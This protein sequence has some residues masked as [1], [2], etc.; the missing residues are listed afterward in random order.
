MNAPAINHYEWLAIDIETSNGRPDDAERAMRAWQPAARWKPETIGARYLDALAA[1]REKLAL[2][3]GAP[4]V[5]VALRSETELRCLHSM[6]AEPPKVLGGGLVEGFATQREML[7]ALRAVLE[8]RVGPDTVIVGHNI[9]GFD[10]RKLRWAY[11]RE[12]VRMPGALVDKDQ[13]V[14][15]SMVEY[16]RR[17][18]MEKSELFVGLDALLEEWGIPTHKATV[19]GSMVPQLHAAG[20]YDS[21]VGYCLLDVLAESDVFLRM[22]GRA[23]DDQPPPT[24]ALPVATPLASAGPEAT[25]VVAA[26]RAETS[27][28]AAPAAPAAP[29]PTAPAAGFSF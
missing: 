12:R 23:A 13:P 5:C 1:K 19:D 3:N 4:I 11:L 26:P 8:A 6:R 10:L 16:G 15:D 7:I 27:S 21:I 28:R 17:F 2:L 29:T 20:Q 24:N 14:Y 9:I 22:T 18:S 25:P